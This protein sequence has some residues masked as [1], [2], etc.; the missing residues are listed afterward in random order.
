VKLGVF[1]VLFSD[2]A[3]ED[4]LD[5]VA[6]AGLDSVEI[7]TGGHPGNAHCN[8]DELLAQPAQLEAF[9]KQVEARHLTISALSCHGNALHPNTEVA[10][11]DADTLTKTMQLAERLGVD[12]VNTF[13]GCPG[14]SEHS[15]HPVWVTCPWPEE[16]SE[17]LEWQWTEKLIPYW[18]EQN[19]FAKQHGVRV[20][21]EA[22]PGFL[23]YNTETMLRLREAAGEQIGINFDPSH[24]FWQGMSPVACIKTL[25]AAGALFHVHA[26]D[27]AFDADNMAQNGVLDTKSYLDERHRSWLFRTVG[28][29]HGESTWRDIVSALQLAGYQ[30][31]VSIEHEDSLMSIDEGFAKAVAFLKPLLIRERLE[32]VWWS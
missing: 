30:G 17:V 12:T 20:A 10:K 15:R 5:K 18:R 26:K 28:Y 11:R 14:E 2:M 27:T 25:G 8:M 24:L 19:A 7:G 4:M 23:V 3:L 22:H 9:R 6:A 29:G 31:T 1:T 16:F 32:R 21:I 13:S